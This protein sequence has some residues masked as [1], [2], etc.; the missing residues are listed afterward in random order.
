MLALSSLLNR[1]ANA[2]SKKPAIVQNTQSFV[3]TQKTMG[4][5][6]VPIFTIFFFF[7]ILDKILIMSIGFAGRCKN[8][9]CGI[10]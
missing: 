6:K 9:E 2:L 5:I 10:I 8:S 1:S 7:L 3:T 4:Q